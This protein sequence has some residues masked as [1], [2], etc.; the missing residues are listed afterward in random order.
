MDADEPTAA[1][2]EERL[3][4]T[5]E[6]PVVPGRRGRVDERIRE[7]ELLREVPR[8]AGDVVHVDA[9]H[10]DAPARKLLRPALERRRLLLARVAPR[11][12][13]VDDD[14]LA[15]QRGER[16]APA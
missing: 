14:R 7:P 3:R 15:A 11:R 6:A 13:E 2:D 16:H 4:D 12:P 5:G 9:E 10:H 8:V 1:V